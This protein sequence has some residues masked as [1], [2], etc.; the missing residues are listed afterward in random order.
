MPGV[1]RG[2]HER[3]AGNSGA[4]PLCYDYLMSGLSLLVLLLAQTPK[5]PPVAGMPAADGVYY[6]L[7]Y[8][9][10]QKLTP[11]PMADMKTKGMGTFIETEGL[12]NIGMDVVYKGPRAAVQI[13]DRLPSLYV[14]G[15]GPANDVVLVQLTQRKDSR[16]VHASS[17]AATLENKGGFRK[18]DIRKVTTTIYTDGSFSVTPEEDLKPGEYLL[19]FGYATAGYDFGIE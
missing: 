10:W 4:H 13:S 5:P 2:S 1:V 6:R 15:T 17:A 12:T 14:R 3:I 18:A 16:S 11:A 8:G 7:G 9:Q 19:A